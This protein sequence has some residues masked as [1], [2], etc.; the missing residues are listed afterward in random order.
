MERIGLIAGSGQFPTIFSKVATE[1]GLKVYAVAHEGETDPRL[2]TFVE[3]VKW[4]KI[5]QLKKIIAFFKKNSVRDAVMAGAITKTKMFSGVR[6]DLMA[7]K[8]LAT[9]DHTQDDGLLRAFAGEME[10]E[11]IT[12]HPSTFL[13]PELLAKKGCWTRRKPT[14]SEMADVRFGWRIVREIGRLDIGQ[15]VVVRGGS[16][17]AV[18]AI[19]GTDATIRRGGRLGKEKT[20]VVKAS[21]P[22]Q[23]MRFDMPAVGLKTIQTMCEVGASVLA[24]E[25]GKTVVFDREEMVAMANQNGIAIVGIEE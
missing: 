10:K 24:I 17:M 25:A 23:D 3:A 20:V 2:A 9:M 19:D 16:V 11:G 22:D 18:E 13:L 5:G 15:S 21:K 8:V 7:L 14:K 6:P 12:I 1:R 4:V